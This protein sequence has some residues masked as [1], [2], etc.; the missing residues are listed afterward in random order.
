VPTHQIAQLPDGFRQSV[1][2]LHR[3]PWDRQTL[4]NTG[5]MK[6]AWVIPLGDSKSKLHIS[7]PRITQ[8]CNYQ[9]TKNGWEKSSREAE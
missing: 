2:A 1:H 4:E 7:L 9:Q 6:R 8:T 5:K 3:L